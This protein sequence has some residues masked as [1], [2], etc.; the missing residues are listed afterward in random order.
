MKLI[1]QTNAIKYP[2]TGIGRYSYE[3]A[4]N[5]TNI[6]G[7]E[8]V[9][10][11]NG[12]RFVESIEQTDPSI[13][14]KVNV[15]KSWVIKS[16]LLTKAYLI[17][18]PIIQSYFLRSYS[19]YIYHGPNYYLPNFQGKSVVTIHDL[20]VFSWSWCHPKNRVKALQKAI[21]NAVKKASILIT[22]S[23]FIKQE[24]IQ[25]YNFPSDK[26]F[27][28]PLAAGNEFRVRSKAE[29]D[30][31]L[32]KYNLD[33]NEYSLFVSTI[34]PRKNL[35]T[36][37]SSY[38][39]LPLGI[40]KQ[41]PLLIIGHGGWK[42]EDVHLIMQEAEAEGW[43]KYIG[44]IEADDLPCIY[45]GARLFIF[46]SFYEGFGLP[47][48]EAMASGVPVVCSNSSSLPEVVGNAAAMCD[49]E[50]VNEFTH[51]I[52]I[53]LVDN[54]WRTNAIEVGLNQSKKFSW[55]KCAQETAKVYQKLI[56]TAD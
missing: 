31:I 54:E 35:K 19:N 16:S 50:N 39:K 12:R 43:L 36:L 20:S 45:S 30:S 52:T 25:F 13:G 47:V 15:I 18:F 26:I 23:E 48:L 32:N 9:K 37:L 3:L 44:Y 14:R 10:Y 1:I 8:N 51:L 33:Y 40:R 7:S 11:F 2:L 22:D 53:G 21:N 38:K 6:Y 4:K 56:D 41:F 49:P 24:I 46:P 34:E 17:I 29:I 28:I 42:S 55:Q 5:L 27:V